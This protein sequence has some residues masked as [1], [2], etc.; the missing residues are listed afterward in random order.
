MD[1]GRF[2]HRERTSGLM[3]SSG[4]PY[5]E[6]IEISGRETKKGLIGTYLRVHTTRWAGRPRR[7]VTGPLPID[8]RRYLPAV[9]AP[10]G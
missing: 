3:W 7:C 1:E 10:A 2:D 9:S 5:T 8:A 6:T 4:T